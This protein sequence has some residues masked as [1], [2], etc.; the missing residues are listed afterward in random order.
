MFRRVRLFGS[1]RRPAA[2]VIGVWDPL[3]SV[4]ARLFGQLRRYSMVRARDTLAILLWPHPASFINPRRH[5]PVYDALETQVELIRSLGIDAVLVIKF[6]RGDADKGAAELLDEIVKWAPVAELWLG[7][8]QSLG[9]CRRGSSATIVAIARKHRIAVRHLPP[10]RGDH[11]T[12]ARAELSQG[13]LDL[14]ISLV[15]RP[16][17]LARPAQGSTLFVGWPDGTYT[18]VAATSALDFGASSFL[19]ISV[20]PHARGSRLVWPDRSVKW[21]AIIKGPAAARHS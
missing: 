4:H 12:S 10:A 13:N 3:V 7:A 20:I 15:G 1:I 11:G 8:R 9:R 2:A 16:P 14:A 19:P 6:S 18:G 5:W 17:V 21:L